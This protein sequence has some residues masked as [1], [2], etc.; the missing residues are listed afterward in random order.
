MTRYHH[1]HHGPWGC[2]FLVPWLVVITAGAVAVTV[3]VTAWLLWGAVVLL[4]AGIAWAAGNR[5]LAERMGRSLNWGI[6]GRVRAG[7]AKGR[8]LA[9]P[10]LLSG[11]PAPGRVYRSPGLPGLQSIALGSALTFGQGVIVLEAS[12]NDLDLIDRSETECHRTR[13]SPSRYPS[14]AWPSSWP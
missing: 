9:R 8:A 3:V 7:R 6:L 11:T 14:S 5:G 4:A 2:L 13:Y 10:L 12:V 1:C